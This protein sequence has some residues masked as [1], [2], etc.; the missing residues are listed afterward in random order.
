MKKKNLILKMY[1]R[2]I[3]MEILFNY[4]ISTDKN[5]DLFIY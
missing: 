2:D 3:K 4:L 5:C 1:F